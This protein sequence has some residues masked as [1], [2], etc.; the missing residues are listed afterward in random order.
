MGLFAEQCTGSEEGSWTLS[1]TVKEISQ[2]PEPFQN[3]LEGVLGM[4][5]KAE[6]AGIL[7]LKVNSYPWEGR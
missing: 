5:E 7:V 1:L 6:R 2:F 3:P 4:G